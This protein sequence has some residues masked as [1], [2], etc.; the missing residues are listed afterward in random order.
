MGIIRLSQCT[1]IL[2]VHRVTCQ[3]SVAKGCLLILKSR[4]AEE[5]LFKRLLKIIFWLI[6]AIVV[7]HIF[8][9]LV[10][11]ANPDNRVLADMTERFGLDAELS[12]PTWL[13][14]MIAFV[15]AGL[16]WV[17]GRAQKDSSARRGW[18]FIAAAGLFV[19]GDEVASLHELL[20]Q[21]LHIVA[22]FGTQTFLDNAWLLLLP[23]L[24]VGGFFIFRYLRQAL[25]G[26]TFR[27]L[28]VAGIVYLLGAFVFEYLSIPMDKSLLSYK[29]GEVV[30]EE[31]L[32]FFGLL[33][34]LRALCHHIVV[35]EPKLRRKLT[36]LVKP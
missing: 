31:S 20:L 10:A 12:I 26:D 19:S 5:P 2:C 33:L 35:H 36:D 24:T 17:I 21:G 9:Q 27:L 18:Y 6:I 22:H 32:E 30:V 4:A 11:S 15:M 1:D 29:I 23:F 25:L 8:W 13:T 16:A 7:L 14:S 28:V 3:Q 34:V